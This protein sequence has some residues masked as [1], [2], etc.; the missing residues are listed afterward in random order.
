MSSVVSDVPEVKKHLSEVIDALKEIKLTIN[1][2]VEAKKYTKYVSMGFMIG[3]GIISGVLLI[4][5]GNLMPP[6]LIATTML[7][8][9][10]LAKVGLESLINNREKYQL[11]NARLVKRN[12]TLSIYLFILT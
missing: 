12:L 2:M 7:G 8:T 1:Q 5:T 11:N 9:G 10:I 4:V 6:I 3:G